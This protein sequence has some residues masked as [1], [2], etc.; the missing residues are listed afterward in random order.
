MH[1]RGGGGSEAHLPLFPFAARKR[2]LTAFGRKKLMSTSIGENIENQSTRYWHMGLVVLRVQ[3]RCEPIGDVIESRWY[4]KTTSH[5]DQ[6][7]N[8][9]VKVIHAFLR[10]LGQ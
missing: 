5:A 6:I 2:H 8:S 7:K 10:L 4:A 1:I 3:L 9:Q